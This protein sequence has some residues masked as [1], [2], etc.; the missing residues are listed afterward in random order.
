MHGGGAVAWITGTLAMLASQELRWLLLQETWH[1][2]FFLACGSSSPVR[3]ECEEGTAPWV[4]G[5]LVV[6]SV[7]GHRLPQPQELWPN[8]SLFLALDN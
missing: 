1:L 3:T 8:Q 5:T 4:L 7:Q 6:P 2:G